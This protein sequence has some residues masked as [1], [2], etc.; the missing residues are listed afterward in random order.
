M[1]KIRIWVILLA[2][3]L[4]GC[5]DSNVSASLDTDPIDLN[6]EQLYYNPINLSLIKFNPNENTSE[7]ITEKETIVYD[8]NNADNYFIKGNPID[9]SFFL[10]KIDG[11]SLETIHE[12]DKGEDI[13]PIG[14][15]NGEIYYIHSYYDGAEEDKDKR[16]IG[17]INIET[18]ETEDI[19][20]IKGLISDGVVSSKNIYYTVFN[21]ENNYHEL[22]NK[23]IEAG[24]KS[25]APELISVGYDT[26]DLYLSKD[27]Y[28]EKEIISLY[29][30]DHNKIYSKDESWPK[31][32]E[33]YFK[34]NAV[35]G[36]NEGEDDTMELTFIDKR[37]REEI[38][39][40]S[41]VI[42]IRFEGDTIDVATKN[43][44]SKY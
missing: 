5:Q 33:N 32:D 30:S 38:N 28:N 36:I 43:G 25:E 14:Y 27:L 18:K 42:G 10:V 19:E 3:F 7:N 9:H 23:S 15:N 2:L 39:K 41:D 11:T 31:Y 37:T 40:L 13:Y 26:K 1:K 22:H 6:V 35:I 20:A 44:A 17:L 24:E 34:T 21:S 29:A 8:I 4:V 16:T 12:F